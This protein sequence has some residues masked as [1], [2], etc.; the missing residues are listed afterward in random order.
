M[1]FEKLY[2]RGALPKMTDL[3]RKRASVLLVEPDNTV[4]QNMRRTLI[5]LGFG[6]VSD[7]A[8]HVQAFRKL[9]ER[10]FSHLIFEAKKTTM[11]ALEFLI[12]VLEIDRDAIM[13]ASSWEPNIDDVFNLLI[14]G[15]RGY[16]VKPF[17]HNSLD[18]AVVMATKGEPISE[19]I[20]YAKDRNEALASLIM[21]ALDKLA[22][23]LRQAQQF[24][25]A[26]RE[27]PRRKLSLERAIDIGRT[28]A[29]GGAGP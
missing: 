6:H 12:K 8:D 18:D 16:L 21:T 27:I 13:I 22:V 2:K 4:K 26:E 7:A 17:T 19:S 10:N 23:A 24:E 3:E 29:E 11:P 5:E 25:T 15:A 20:L 9:A 28:F 1:S 14:H